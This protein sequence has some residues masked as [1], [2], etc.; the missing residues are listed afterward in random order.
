MEGGGLAGDCLKAAFTRILFEFMQE[1]GGAAIAEVE[2]DFALGQAGS[3]LI[4]RQAMPGGFG[5]DCVQSARGIG[6]AFHARGND[7]EI[8]AGGHLLAGFSLWGGAI[9]L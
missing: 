4:G 6:G 2:L 9:Q 3:E 7:G 5:D 8:Q 1:A